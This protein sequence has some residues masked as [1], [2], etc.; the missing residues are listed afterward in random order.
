[1][2]NPFERNASK[3]LWFAALIENRVWAGQERTRPEMSDRNAGTMNLSS[4]QR[5]FAAAAM[6]AA[7]TGVLVLSC[8]AEAQEPAA[9]RNPL[10]PG[11][12]AKSDVSAVAQ[13]L[14]LEDF[15]GSLVDQTVVPVPG[16]IFSVMDKIG[17]PD[18]QG[19]L[20]SVTGELSADRVKLSLTFGATVA[21]GFLAVQAEEVKTVKDLGRRLLKLGSAL[22]IEDR[23]LP[24]YRSILESAESADWKAVRAEIDRT[25][26]TVRQSMEELRDGDLATLVSL[27]GWLRGTETL[28]TLITESYS[29]DRAELLNQ[30]DLVLH[31]V[32]TVGAMNES[33]RDHEDV[34]AIAKGLVEIHQAMTLPSAAPAAND[35]ADA[36]APAGED[37]A[38]RPPEADKDAPQTRPLAPVASVAGSATATA[39]DVDAV[40]R[41]REVCQKVLEGFYPNEEADK[42]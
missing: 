37:K 39:I 2:L 33:L 1:M 38:A 40:R 20:R 10:F 17:A 9:F 25:Q 42:G 12:V 24:H 8:P 34:V 14:V 16:E 15:P 22:G 35:K 6:L 31:F 21:E 7:A 11:A 29:G 19:Q 32:K 4:S 3:T 30:P 41:I 26:Q 28:T 5:I 13:K 36:A 23:V 27:G 18:W